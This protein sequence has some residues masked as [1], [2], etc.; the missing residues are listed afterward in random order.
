MVDY[1]VGIYL[2][3]FTSFHLEK[4]KYKYT[5]PQ[6]IGTCIII[7]YNVSITNTE[8]TPYNSAAVILI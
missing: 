2:S 1:F 6:N 4:I 5:L 7:V 8:C 3:I